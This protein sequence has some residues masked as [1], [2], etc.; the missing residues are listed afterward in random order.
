MQLGLHIIYFYGSDGSDATS[1]NPIANGDNDGGRLFDKLNHGKISLPIFAPES[2]PVIGG[3][4]A[5]LFLVTTV[6][7][8][9]GVSVSGRV[10]TATDRGLRNAV[11]T[12]TNSSGITRNAITSSFG[13]YSFDDVEAGGT[14][15]IGVS[16]KRYHFSPRVMSVTNELQNLDFVAVP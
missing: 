9:G 3:I 1:I 5:Y 2:S 13:Y 10:L 8:A 16:S 15:V 4:N 7:T 6:P 14:Y 12:L 11:V